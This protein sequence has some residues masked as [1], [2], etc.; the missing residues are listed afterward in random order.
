[1]FRFSFWQWIKAEFPVSDGTWFCQ[2]WPSFWFFPLLLPPFYVFSSSCTFFRSSAWLKDAQLLCTT[3]FLCLHLSGLRF[4]M[5]RLA[6]KK[7]QNCHTYASPR[8]L[9]TRVT[10]TSAWPSDPS[11]SPLATQQLASFVLKQSVSSLSIPCHLFLI[12]QSHLIYDQN[13]LI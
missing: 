8:W 11:C 13:Q 5:W 9:S 6:L 2:L 7:P 3:V 4:L 12:I 1:M 10:K